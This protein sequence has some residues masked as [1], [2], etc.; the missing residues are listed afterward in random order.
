[1]QTYLSVR[2]IWKISLKP[3]LQ[4]FTCWHTFSGLRVTAEKLLS[5]TINRLLQSLKGFKTFQAMNVEP[6]SLFFQLCA[7]LCMKFGNDEVVCRM[8]IKKKKHLTKRQLHLQHRFGF[9][10]E[11]TF[12]VIT[13][14]AK[15]LIG[16][17]LSK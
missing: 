17:Y 4:W 11:Q 16:L 15:A 8:Q 5:K 14:S 9:R 7:Y 12:A 1:M 6:M 2:P 13:A 3:F 10:K